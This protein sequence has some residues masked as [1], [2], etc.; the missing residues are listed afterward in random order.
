MRRS[1]W[2]RKN[3]KETVVN[4]Q[5]PEK[6]PRKSD[7]ILAAHLPSFVNQSSSLPMMA[8]K[9]TLQAQRFHVRRR[10]EGRT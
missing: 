1:K 8:P 9:F 3:N 4:F 7:F 5:T 2:A 10:S 6:T